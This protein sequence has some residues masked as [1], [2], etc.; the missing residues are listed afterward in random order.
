LTTR[1][2]LPASVAAIYRAV[3]ELEAAY[4]GRNFTPDGH[5]VGSIGEVIAAENLGLKLYPSGHPVHD[6]YD[7]NG[8]VQIKMTVDDAFGMYGPCERLLVLRIVS[9]EEAEI[10]FFGCGDLAWASAGKPRT[11]GQRVVRLAKLRALAQNGG[12]ARR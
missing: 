6:A 3:A 4:P 12:L 7:D 2:K 8:D 1:I 5:L 9:P 11:N 10:V